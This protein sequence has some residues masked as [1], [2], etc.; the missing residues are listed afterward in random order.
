MVQLIS[1]LAVQ[2]GLLTVC[3]TLQHL[4]Y[5]IYL[6]FSLTLLNPSH[7]RIQVFSSLTIFP[8]YLVLHILGQAKREMTNRRQQRRT[9][10]INGLPVDA[11][12]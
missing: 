3:I 5:R 4:P 11:G 1:I 9:R 7:R 2:E 6:R 12:Q 8:L 10:R